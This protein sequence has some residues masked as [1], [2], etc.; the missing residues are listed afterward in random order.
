LIHQSGIVKVVYHNAYKDDSG[1]KFLERAGIELELI[2]DL[3]E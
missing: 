1:L 3:E 2:E